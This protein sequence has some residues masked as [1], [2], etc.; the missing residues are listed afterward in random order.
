M[1]G[2]FFHGV[3]YGDTLGVFLETTDADIRI[4]SFF[5]AA[6]IFD[7]KNFELCRIPDCV[8]TK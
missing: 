6:P 3:R 1:E 2:S 4:E 5:V 8:E 7:F